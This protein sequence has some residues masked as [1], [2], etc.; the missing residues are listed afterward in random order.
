MKKSILVG[1]LAVLGFA[2]SAQKTAEKAV[3]ETVIAFAKAGDAQ[4]AALL[5]TYLDA[6]YRVVMN[7]LFGSSELSV[8]SREVY[9][10]KI[11]SKVFGGDTRTFEF[12]EIAVNGNTAVVR[13]NMNG[14]KMKT[15][16]TLLL[17]QNESGKWLL[18]CDMPVIIP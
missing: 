7:R 4:D 11:S 1:C 3:K 10:E 8:L 13:V 2:A 16:S 9:L 12:L 17:A 5:A 6:H 18:V 14:S 15:C